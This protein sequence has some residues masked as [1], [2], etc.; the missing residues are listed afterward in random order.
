MSILSLGLGLKES[1]VAMETLEAPQVMWASFAPIL[2]VFGGAVLAILV[3]A[4]ASVKIRRTLVIAVSL[5]TVLSATVLLVVRWVLVNQNPVSAGEYVDDQ[6]TIASQFLLMVIGFVALLVMADRS[7]LGDGHFASQPSDR[8]GSIDEELSDKKNYQRSEIFPLALFSLGGMMV[9]P[10]ANSFISLFVA[11]E[12]MS[13]PL[14]ILAATARRRRQLSQE[15]A[16]KYFVLGAFASA[17]MLMGAAFLYGFSG[18]LTISDIPAAV[19]TV[20]GKDWLLVAGIFMVMVGLLFKVGAAPFHAWTP[21]VYTGAPTPVTGFMASAVKVAAFAAM[22]RFFQVVAAALRWDLLPIMLGVVV[23]TLLVG[24]FVGLVQRDVKRMLAYSSI[25][26]AGFVLLGVFSLQTGSTG[27]VLFYLFGYGLATVGAFA[28]IS[29]VRTISADGVIT[30][31][32]TDI[33]R[34]AGIGKKNPLFAGLM[35]LFLLSFA[36]IP[37]TGGFI[38]KFVVFSDAFAGGLGWFVALAL[39]CSAVTA[40]FYFRLV[41]LMFFTEETGDVTVVKSEGYS[42]IALVICALGTIILG[43]F[44]GPVLTLL[45]KVAILLP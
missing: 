5:L 43:V 17:F 27:H 35:L 33:N 36:G 18:S 29:Q 3:E 32:V 12:V 31:E 42:T 40:F 19:A 22:I 11:L 25:A 41:R 8:P 26:H 28:L 15:A 2:V 1:L 21:D 24:T 14:Y 38:G 6:L 39:I 7:I 23:L 13:L 30:S 9:F 20:D 44:P 4:F 34:W 10:A 16:L 37:L 45:A